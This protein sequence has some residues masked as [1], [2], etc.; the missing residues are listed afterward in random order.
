VVQLANSG[1]DVDMPDASNP[2]TRLSFR[3]QGWLSIPGGVTNEDGGGSGVHFAW[4]LDGA[5][6]L[7]QQRLLPGDSDAEWLVS[8][9]CSFLERLTGGSPAAHHL[10]ALSAFL[11]SRFQAARV[12]AP[13]PD[14]LE[15]LP[16][17]SLA[18]AAIEGQLLEIANIGDCR[19]L[20]RF[21]E[22]ATRQFGDSPVSALDAQVLRR[23]V[24]LQRSDPHA[25]Y[26]ALRARLAPLIRRNRLLKNQPNGYGVLEPRDSWLQNVQY[27]EAGAPP[28]THVLMVSDGFYRL[29]D[30]YHLYDDES[31]LAAALD[32]GLEVLAR[33]LRQVEDE[34][35]ECRA[36]PRLKPRD[37]A[38]ALLLVV[39]AMPRSRG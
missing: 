34:D 22:G 1:H 19:T 28:G 29:V 7:P 23:L 16:S 32:D 14:R 17:A 24:E 25:S 11:S 36:H 8:E 2:H 3:R 13:S 33:R 35:P 5:T 15:E 6:G 10:G 31:L 27:F 18:F 4:L 39:E 20:V 37:D 30:H 26:G 12:R 38:S 9:S 21:P